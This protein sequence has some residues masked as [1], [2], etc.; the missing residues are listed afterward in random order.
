MRVQ[1]TGVP[2]FNG[3][4]LMTLYY[5]LPE[6]DG[7]PSLS[8]QDSDTLSNLTVL[9]Q[10]VATLLKYGSSGRY[11]TYLA[12]SWEATSDQRIWTFRLN[13]D[14]VADDGTRIDALSF[15]RNFKRLLNI[16]RLN[17][18]PP[19]FKDL[20][21]WDEFKLGNES[22]LGIDTPSVDVLIFRFTKPPAGLLEFLSMPMYGFYADRDFD[23]LKWKDKTQITASGDYR[24]LA[25]LENGFELG[26]RRENPGS[27][28][29]KVFVN[30]FTQERKKAVGS[31]AVI[32]SERTNPWADLPIGFERITGIPTILHGLVVTP[33]L[34]N[35]FADKSNRQVFAETVLRINRERPLSYGNSAL[36]K[37]FYANPSPDL[38]TKLRQK[39]TKGSMA[40]IESDRSI[41][42]VV[43]PSEPPRVIEHIKSIF[44]EVS[45][46]HGLKIE[47]VNE[48]RTDPAWEE[49]RYGNNFFDIRPAIVEVGA[50]I[51]DWAVNMMFCSSLGISF[52]DPSGE[53]CKIIHGH[54]SLSEI[55]NELR[56]RFELA[57]ADD[58]VVLPLYHTGQSWLINSKV[59]KNTISPTMGLPRFITLKVTE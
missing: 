10:V 13:L 6:N 30:T 44:D 39:Q 5:F 36:A 2:E 32:V 26:I 28:P 16:H 8:V 43:G 27:A 1:L 25:K 48:D 23:G 40:K 9:E 20:V 38:E 4:N 52:P 17:G 18:D 55:S 21:G 29:N 31:A 11:E 49:R 59:D 47:M 41:R 42:C 58:A 19:T 54:S 45:K 35:V 7:S 56:E 53:I 34:E 37:A 3:R 15:A 22:N 24:V 50:Q 14:F 46:I 33:N 12:K 57:V 51:Q